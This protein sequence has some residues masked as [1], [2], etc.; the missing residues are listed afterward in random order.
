MCCEARRKTKKVS[1]KKMIIV[2]SFI[3]I[4]LFKDVVF[5]NIKKPSSNIVKSISTLSI[6]NIYATAQ[7]VS[8]QIDESTSE[9][10]SSQRSQTTTDLISE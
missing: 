7:D 8:L 10:F 4:C 1:P 6:T 5:S 2:I 3:K 9:T